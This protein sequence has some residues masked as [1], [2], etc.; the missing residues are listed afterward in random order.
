MTAAAWTST[1]ER[2]NAAVLRLMA[3]IALGLGWHVGHALL[4]PVTLFFLAGILN[5]PEDVHNAAR[6]DGANA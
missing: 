6:T 1:P 3:R 4:H 5:I 2:G